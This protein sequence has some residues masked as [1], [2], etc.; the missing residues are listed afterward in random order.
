[1]T[2]YVFLKTPVDTSQINAVYIFEPW[3][4]LRISTGCNLNMQSTYINQILVQLVDNKFV[5]IHVIIS[6]YFTQIYGLE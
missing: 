1:M 3:S 2:L 5:C 4:S 6:G